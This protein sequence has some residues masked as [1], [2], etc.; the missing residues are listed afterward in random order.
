M[1]DTAYTDALHDQFKDLNTANFTVQFMPPV[2]FV[3]GGPM[4]PVYSSLRERIFTYTASH[5]E[6]LHDSLVLAEN[7]K[8]YFKDGAYSDL[9]QFE[10]DIANIS[11]LIVI[12]LESAGSLVE[13][14]LFVNR[15]SL[16]QRLLVIVPAEE[17]EENLEKKTPARS[18]FIYLGPLEHLKRLDADS[19]AIYPWPDSKSSKY[20]EIDLIIHDV[21]KRLN[22]VKK[23]EKFNGN[24]TGHLAILIFEIILLT[25]PIKLTEI[26]WTLLCME[27]EFDRN[28]VSRL[29]Y[30]LDI[31]NLV[32]FMPYSGTD[33]Y[34]AKKSNVSKIKFGKTKTDKIQDALNMKVAIR[35]SYLSFDGDNQDETAKKRRNVFI[36]INDLR[37]KKGA[38]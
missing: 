14:G 33:Y 31:M 36:R 1:S 29:L 6:K 2:V 13:L 15:K 10:E 27:I 30:L 19:V 12:C 9:M 35:Q 28:L 38:E 4:L 17:V 23:T 20:Q 16:A 24:N 32:S 21:N 5:D 37:S 26:E 3:C 25:E 11:T 34:Y 7:F 8:D 18:S 22:S